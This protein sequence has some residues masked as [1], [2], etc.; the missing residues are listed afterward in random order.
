[1][2]LIKY[3][4]KIPWFCPCIIKWVP[5]SRL[6]RRLF[7]Q[8]STR[9]RNHKY[10]GEEITFRASIDMERLPQDVQGIPMVR[11]PDIVRELFEQLIRRTT[12]NLGPSDLIRF[13]IQAEGLDKSISTYLMV[14]STLTVEK[15]WLPS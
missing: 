9:R 15:F 4:W 13:C 12:A 8:K 6:M 10:Q 3:S 5:D 1:M 14:V 2:K 7:S 11:I